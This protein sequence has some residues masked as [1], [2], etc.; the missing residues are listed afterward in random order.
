MRGARAMP[1]LRHEWKSRPLERLAGM[2]WSRQGDRLTL[3]AGVTPMTRHEFKLHLL[4]R[5]DKAPCTILT[6][7]TSQ[8]CRQVTNARKFWRRWALWLPKP[9]PTPYIDA[10]PADTS[11]GPGARGTT[12]QSSTPNGATQSNTAGQGVENTG[13]I[14]AQA[15]SGDG[16]KIGT[17]STT[18]GT[19]G[20]SGNKRLLGSM[21]SWTTC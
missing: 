21:E 3:S 13:G 17:G 12:A 15:D 20:S 18:R 9:L 8:S 2:P 5:L 10:S 6:P 16:N 7:S 1:M 4:W 11:G 19:R 14:H